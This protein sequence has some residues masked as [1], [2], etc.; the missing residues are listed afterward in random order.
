[1]L[2]L[3]GALFVA[4][5]VIG[6][7]GNH[8]TAATRRRVSVVRACAPEEPAEAVV[9]VADDEGSMTSSS[10]TMPML[11]VPL[12]SHSDSGSEEEGVRRRVLLIYTGGT[13]GMTKQ[14]DGALAPKKGYLQEVI[15]EMPEMRDPSMPELDLIEY[16]PLLDSSNVSP[17]DWSL[18][19]KTISDNYYDYDGFV[20]VHGTDT[21]A[22][23]ASALSFMLEG[24]GKAVV[25]T[26]SM[27]PLA[28]VYNDARRNLVIS[29]VF[30]AQL[31]LCE[32]CA[33][34]P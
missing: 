25:L 18:L 5:Y 34:G 20:I 27:I 17:E 14:A 16:D 21:L 19:A 28:E 7:P 4:T 13:L 32:V 1:M 9:G 24:L 12:I 26:G 2:P 3:Y 33:A 6:S 29:M 11:P 10:S 31:E 23:T 22:Y 30:A 8:H 15:V